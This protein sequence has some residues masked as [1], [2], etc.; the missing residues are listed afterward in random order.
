MRKYIEWITSHILSA[1][2]QEKLKQTKSEGKIKEP[3]A[4]C[5]MH[6]REFSY[7]NVVN[8]YC[9]YQMLVLNRHNTFV[10]IS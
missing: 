7:L 3:E 10:N 2:Q 9:R 1:S 6:S 4:K 5:H 8:L